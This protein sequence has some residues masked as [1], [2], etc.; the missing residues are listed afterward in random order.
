[1]AHQI[2]GIDHVA[3]AVADLTE[4]NRR[5]ARLG[6][7]PS[8][9]GSHPEW[10]TANRCLMFARDY[11]ELLAATGA[12]AGAE[13][14]RAHL[15]A[16]GEGMMGVALGSRDATRS[17]ESLNRAGVAAGRPT[18]LS[19]QLDGPEGEVTPRFTVVDL[20]PEATPGLPAFLCQHLTPELLRRPEWLAH[21]NGA[22]GIVSLTVLVEQPEALMGIY[23]KVFGPGAA[24][25]T[26][27]MVT[28]HSGRGL[29]F[30]VTADGFDHLH[31][32]M[33]M[34]LPSPPALVAL[35]IAVEDLD[36]AHGLLKANG[37]R[38]V[39]KG[40]HLEVDPAEVL[41]IGLEFVER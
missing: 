40:G 27:E 8:P 32:D 34:D 16:R 15:A 6:F 22:I 12:G 20:P 25:P 33:V 11:V 26:D 5:F 41:G 28:V 1:M 4:A 39:R 23:D 2:T 29:L 9:A 21:P 31:P 30:L 10:G 24:T 18:A 17:A 35:S 14:V 37:V 13:R 38:C 7:I 19:R 36:L 3:V